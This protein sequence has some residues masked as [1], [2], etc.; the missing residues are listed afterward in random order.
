MLVSAYAISPA[1]AAWMGPVILGLMLAIP[2]NLLTSSVGAG[3]W[4]RRIGLLAR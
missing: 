2:L 1:L 3:Q 4:L